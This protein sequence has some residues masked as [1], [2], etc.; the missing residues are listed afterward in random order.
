MKIHREGTESILIASLLF[1]GLNL[2]N[3]LFLKEFPYASVLLFLITSIV[4]TLV[5]NFFRVPKRNLTV[6]N[7]LII[8]PCD[9]KVVAV[10]QVYDDY[11]MEMRTQVSIFMSVLDVHVNRNPIDGMVIY[12]QY[13][14]G[15]Y[16]FA[17]HPKSSTDNE[18]FISVYQHRN[19]RTLLTKQIAGA[20]A[21]RIVNYLVVS[22]SAYQSQEMGF[23]KFGSRMDVL[24][25]LEAEVLVSLGDRPKG[26]VTAIARW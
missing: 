11:H 26:G 12:K 20:L 1:L 15:K 9:G 4:L 17:W 5:I 8:A 18:R 22:Q 25:P 10:E 7:D 21:K 14:S 2:L 19:G 13:H 6:S 24:L 3:F 16:L 23:I